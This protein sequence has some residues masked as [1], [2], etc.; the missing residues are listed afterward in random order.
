MT[1]L[2]AAAAGRL[3]LATAG[4]SLVCIAFSGGAQAADFDEM[5]VSVRKRDENLQRV[6]VA[7]G[8]L[9]EEQLLKLNI[10]SLQDISRWN[11]SVTFDQGF[12][13]Q[14]TRITIRGLHPSRGRQN[15]AVL[16]DGIDVSGLAVQ[17]NGGTLLINQRLFDM[18]RVEIVKGPQ[19]A[20]YG[21]AAFNGAIN[22]V[23]K[24]P[25][26]ELDA[27]VYADVGNNAR[28]D[29]RGAVSGPLVG[30][31]L[32]GGINVAAWGD[33]G[34]YKNS[35]TGAD[36]GGAEGYGASG[37]L[38]WNVTDKFAA[39]WRLEY[40][41]DEFDQSPYTSIIPSVPAPIPSSA[42]GPVIAPSVTSIDAVRG[43][44]PK[45]DTMQVTLSEDPRTGSDYPGV[46]REL[47][48]TALTLDWAFDAVTLVSLT[49]Y[50][51]ATVKNFEDARR[52]GSIS[53]AGKTTGGEFL[54]NDE[55]TQFSQEL[56]LQS[57]GDE[58]FDWVVGAQYW[59][60][61]V[62]FTDASVNCVANA[63]FV[64]FPPPGF[65]APGVNCAAPLAAIT[66]SDRNA[67]L[68]TRDQEH[69]SVYALIDWE[70]TENWSIILEGRYSDEKITV[71]G[72]DRAGTPSPFDDAPR[73]IDP[74]GIIFPTSVMPAFGTI[75]D[76]V[77]DDFF[78]PKATL[79]WQSS[80]TKMWYL[81]VAQSFKPAGIAISGSLT[82]FNPDS[83]KFEQ[84]E[85][86]VYELGGK[87][88]W[89]DDRLILNG[90]LFFQDFS[91]KQVTSQKADASG[92][93]FPAP[94]NAAS[95]E[96]F[97][98]ELE[99]DWQ[100]TDALNLFASW[101]YLDSE[102]K[103]YSQLSQGPAPIA[104]AGNCTVV[105]PDNDPSTKDFC[106]LN[107]S[108]RSLE[109]VPK[110]AIVAGL[111]W[112]KEFVRGIDVLFG[113]NAIYQSDRW[114]SAFNVVSLSSHSV[115]DFRFGFTSDNWS[116]IGYIDNAFEDS[117]VKSTFANTY[118][119]GISTAAPPF[120]FILPLNQTPI[121]PP[122]Q[123]FGLRMSYRFGAS[124]Q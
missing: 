61:N 54:A 8:V 73:A 4:L 124:A 37:S 102:Y 92:V 118:N 93:L 109:Y 10:T 87:T 58:R 80:D 30:D 51:D 66:G 52:E 44:I 7:V 86:T 33:D 90:A 55:T 101:T 39:T 74:R 85:L 5:V 69:W 71:S 121:L 24:K 70:F 20:L 31:T 64:P 94:V 77:T 112:Q 47:F 123:S 27:S 98:L 106:D 107:L 79:Q 81:S 23:T 104:D 42:L 28:Y 9:N 91:D 95:A 111:D 45:G 105:D 22:Y 108:G 50:T 32:L 62:D 41:D 110:H 26:D 19:N 78:A 21:R 2:G 25:T 6:P 103:D 18:E 119:Q 67:D 34:F 82:G 63:T 13:S 113:M 11:T 84:E 56:R 16:V 99:A 1:G 60:E 120:T 14:D 49:G 97:G 116:V 65:F 57:N 72:P 76:S 38:I 114:T 43:E 35:A 48:R 83:S 89:A 59:E 29:V 68:W 96:V 115:V 100:A 12:A 40:T 36:V 3:K 122:E 117:N 46:D 15:V 17:T 88:S 53:A 75:T